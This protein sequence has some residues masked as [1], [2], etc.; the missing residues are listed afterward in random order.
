MIN[1]LVY[2]GGHSGN[3]SFLIIDSLVSSEVLIND[4]EEAR[5][6]ESPSGSVLRRG[7][8]V[9][10]GKGIVGGFVNQSTNGL[11]ILSVV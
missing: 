5:I 2:E 3:L 1:P 4:G 7:M 11:T 10:P 9:S 6:Q 8:D